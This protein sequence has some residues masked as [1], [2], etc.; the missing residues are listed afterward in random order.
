MTA[1]CSH[2]IRL[3]GWHER[4]DAETGELLV[5]IF[6][7]RNP[8]GVLLVACGDRRAAS[9]PRARSSIATTRSSSSLPS[10]PQSRALRTASGT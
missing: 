2:P 6:T 5:Q 7:A 3:R 10:L 1:A 9:C 4:I 8:G